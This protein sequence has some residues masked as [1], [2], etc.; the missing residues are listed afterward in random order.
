[1]Y[2]LLINKNEQIIII[3]IKYTCVTK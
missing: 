3:E 1:M 2:K